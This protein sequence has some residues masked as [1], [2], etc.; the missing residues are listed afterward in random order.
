[1]HP[2]ASVSVQVSND[3]EAS[4]N[5]LK[6]VGNFYMHRKDVAEIKQKL[7][8][9]VPEKYW[10]TLAYYIHGMC[11]KPQYD[12]DMNKYLTTDEAKYLHNELL[13]R[14][15]FNAHFSR[16]PP[17]DVP[18]TKSIKAKPPIPP[19]KPIFHD[20]D[21]KAIQF[22]PTTAFDLG[23]I[24]SAKDLGSRINQLLELHKLTA[25]QEAIQQIYFGLRNYILK[26]LKKSY[27]MI[28]P[29]SNYIEAK[30]VS[31]HNVLYILRSNEALSSI[32]SLSVITKYS[33][34]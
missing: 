31:A 9:I 24:P 18:I 14:I 4:L 7:Q 10:S 32:V 33:S 22:K 34:C 27:E 29:S 25:D 13:R 28:S 21:Y 2:T 3:I 19:I 12:H 23:Y 5:A 1:M 15:I 17:P 16:I 11:P 26:L 30:K 8:K 20:R 6:P